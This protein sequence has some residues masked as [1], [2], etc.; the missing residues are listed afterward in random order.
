MTG[1]GIWMMFCIIMVFC[2]LAEYG[3]ILFLNLR[4]RMRLV[5]IRPALSH[6]GRDIKAD[7]STLPNNSIKEKRTSQSLSRILEDNH[8]D[9]KGVQGAKNITIKKDNAKYGEYRRI[10][11]FSL[12]LFPMVFFCFATTYFIVFCCYLY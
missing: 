3:V 8:E 4:N 10:D 12:I 9:T 11:L 7:E 2:A 5:N 1:S 6:T